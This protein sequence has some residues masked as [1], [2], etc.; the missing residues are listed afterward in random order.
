VEEM[1]GEGV[2]V[3]VDA[4]LVDDRNVKAGSTN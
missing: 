2:E 3:E 4:A 1:K